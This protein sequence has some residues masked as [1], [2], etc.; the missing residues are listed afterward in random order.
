M[1][2]EYIYLKCERIISSKF[3]G[4]YSHGELSNNVPSEAV[5]K[6]ENFKKFEFD[7]QC[8]NRWNLH[9]NEDKVYINVSEVEFLTK[10]EMNKKVKFLI[11]KKVEKV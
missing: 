9:T 5:L 10:E 4:M 8:E 7:A 2:K 11:S 1:D 6:L 3:S